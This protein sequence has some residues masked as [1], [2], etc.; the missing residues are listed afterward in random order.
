MIIPGQLF[1]D[2]GVRYFGPIDGHNIELMSDILERVK[3]INYGPKIIHVLTKKGKG[4]RPAEMNPACSTASAPSTWPPAS[5]RATRLSYSEIA[6]KTL[7]HL[8]QQGQEASS[9]SPRR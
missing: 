8:A 3:E 2:M 7:A 9:P 1:E 5:R 6:G 4:Y